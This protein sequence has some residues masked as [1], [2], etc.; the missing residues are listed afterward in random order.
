MNKAK[1]FTSQLVHAERL[2]NLEQGAVHQPAHHS[3]LFAYKQ[4]Q[5]LVDVFQGRSKNHAYARQS[6]PSVNV[7][8][9]TI[10]QLEQAHASLVFSTGMAALTTSMLTLLKAGDHV[11]FSQFIFGNTNSFAQ[12]LT[13][14]GIE[15]DFVDITNHP[16]IKQKIKSNTR[17]LFCETIANPVTQV[18]DIQHIKTL[19]TPQNIVLVV[20]NT[21]TPS[22]LFNGKQ[23]GADLL[24][25]SLTKYFGG[26]GNA[27]GGVVVDT[28]NYNW[29][30]YPNILDTYKNAEPAN[31]AITQI[32]K[33]GLRDMGASISSEA[34]HQLSVGSE[35]MALRLD[36]SCASALQIAQFLQQHD[37]ISQVYYPGL[38]SHPQHELAKKQFKHF[39]AILSFDLIDSI[40]C[41]EF[42]NQLNLILCS[43]HLGDNR[44]LS[45]PVAPT[46]YYEM[47]LEKRQAM[48][49]REGM[50]RLSVGIE[51][52]Q[53]IIDDLTQALDYFA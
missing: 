18:A 37:K 52:C 45:I 17:M 9:N 51:D 1:G 50:I 25:T 48:G 20:D 24:I 26:H 16:Q 12:T 13:Q 47:G 30:N 36:R 27:L 28:G 33:K 7:L 5:E 2:Q 23:L 39:G 41:L 49:I 43:T 31:W 8:Q 46:I 4:S 38:P 35:T 32:K 44:T 42:I 14:Y 6:T 40:D 53:D 3:V 10:T 29:Q 22:Y 11:I 21:M 34:I 15:V 19:C